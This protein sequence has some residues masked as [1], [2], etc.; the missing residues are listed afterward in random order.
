[1]NKLKQYIQKIIKEELTNNSIKKTIV[2]STFTT[3][4]VKHILVVDIET[5]DFKNG[6][7]YNKEVWL[8]QS[9]K[10]FLLLYPNKELKL[11]K[12]TNISLEFPDNKSYGSIWTV[13]GVLTDLQQLTSKLKTNEIDIVFIDTESSELL[14]NEMVVDI[15]QLAK[16]EEKQFK[17]EEEIKQYRTDMLNLIG[18]EDTINNEKPSKERNNKIKQ[19]VDKYMN[20]MKKDVKDYYKNYLK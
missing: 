15:L 13:K 10:S 7:I 8:L 2:E 5:G 11:K 16:E 4:P 14:T 17:K 9:N 19:F 1:M 18:K 12:G 20:Y 6:T 3:L